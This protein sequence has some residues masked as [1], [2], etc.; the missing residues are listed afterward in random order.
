VPLKTVGQSPVLVKDVGYAKDGSQSSTTSCVDGQP[1]VYLP[2]FKQGGDSNTIS[3]VNG[4][5]EAITKD[6]L[7]VP[8]SLVT[9]VVFDQSVFVKTAIETCCMKAPSAFA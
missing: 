8:K 7:D 2:V 5:K 4:V 9:K 3:I 6:L 1:S